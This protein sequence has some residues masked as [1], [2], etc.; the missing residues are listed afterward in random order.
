MF[1]NSTNPILK[2][3]DADL[4]MYF[5]YSTTATAAREFLE[6]LEGGPDEAALNP[7]IAASIANATMPE[8]YGDALRI[9]G[10]ENDAIKA[11]RGIA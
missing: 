10:L 3:F 2:A 8:N 7:D 9:R 6:I 11:L 5:N 1:E 4:H